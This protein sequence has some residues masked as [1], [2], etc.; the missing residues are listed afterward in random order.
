MGAGEPAVAQALLSLLGNLG[1]VLADD[2]QRRA[3]VADQVRRVLA[4]AECRSPQAADLAAIQAEA[5]RVL[6]EVTI[7]NSDIGPVVPH[8]PG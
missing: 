2:E 1:A 6:R 3:T 5:D 4:D 7:R 8:R